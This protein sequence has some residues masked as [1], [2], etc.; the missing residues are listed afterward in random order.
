MG[1]GVRRWS[2]APHCCNRCLSGSRE[3]RGIPATFHLPPVRF[4]LPLV[5]LTFFKNQQGGWPAPDRERKR[6]HPGTPWPTRG[7]S[8]RVVPKLH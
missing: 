7:T 4:H 5:P 6:I 3:V 2:G 8:D 1:K